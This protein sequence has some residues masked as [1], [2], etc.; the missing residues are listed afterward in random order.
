MA[1]YLDYEFNSYSEPQIN[2][3][4]GSILTIRNG[5][6]NLANFWLKGVDPSAHNEYI[7]SLISEGHIFYAY[8]NTAEARA[9]HSLGIDPRRIKW[10]DLATEYRMLMNHNHTYSTGK[11][12]VKGQIKHIFPPIPKWEKTEGD[13]P[14]GVAEVSLASCL[15]KFLGIKIDTGNKD[16]MRDLILSNK[17]FTARER[18]DII[19]YCA[20]DVK[21]L[22]ALAKKMYGA[23]HRSYDPGDRKSLKKEILLRGEYGARTAIMES[24][25]YPIDYT[26]TESFAA[27]V[28][29]MLY[30]LQKEISDDFP[31]INPFLANKQNTA[32]VQKQKNIRAWVKEQGHD[33]WLETDKGELSLSLEAFE[34]FY[35]SRGDQEN[36][37]NRFTKYLRTKQSLNGFMPARKGATIWDYVGSD[38]RVRPYFGIFRAQSGRSQPKATSYIPLKAKWMRCLIQPKP[39][40]AIVAI[41]YSQQEFLI[42]GLI[43]QDEE[44]IKA[45]NSGDVY[46]YFGKQAKAI[47]EDGTKADFPDERDKFKSTTLGIQYLMG[48]AGLAKKLSDDTG[49][50]HTEDEAQELI[51]LYNEVYSTYADFRNETWYDYGAWGYLKLPCGW[52]IYGDNS[53][54]RSVCN[55]PVQGLGAS[56]MRKGVALAQDA[57]LKVIMTLHDAIY[58]ECPSSEYEH[59][60]EVL[61]ECMSEAFKFYFL[62]TPMEPYANCRMDPTIWSPDYQ[63]ETVETV[64][65]PCKLMSRYIEE[66]SRADYEKY[67]KFFIDQD[68]LDL[69]M[70][71]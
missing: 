48:N 34:R 31:S 59:Y 43:S 51:D 5:V 58:I 13:P 22:P 27:S 38:E 7:E 63:D 64:L 25:G 9:L 33:N 57:G 39:G 12:L 17:D 62:D 65:G 49:V 8:Y 1:V 52:T 69:L 18:R 11:H 68:E 16:E 47:P 24:E 67:S 42:A 26:A 30:H 45:Y 3:V 21:H 46:L 60:T 20:S 66:K 15:Y 28:K 10:V 19:K 53:N 37:G 70:G 35:S 2:V 61:A 44:M 14:S 23:L 36:F 54:R 55:F 6:E 56:I 71:L 32:F 4:C 50:P 41:D 29:P 40:K